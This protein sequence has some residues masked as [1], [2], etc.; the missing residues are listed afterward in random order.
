[1]S[2]SFDVKKQPV[3]TP[4][5]LYDV[6][7]VGA[8]PYGLSTTAHIL[9]RGLRVR[10]FG[11]PLA[12]WREHMPEH[13]LL[14][15]YWWATNLSD[16]QHRYGLERYLQA[17]GQQAI[18][19]LPIETFIDYG[20]WFQKQAVPNVDETYVESIERVE[21][22][23][24]LTL[25]DGRVVHSRAVVMAPGLRYYT[26]CP[27]EYSH[28]PSEF[29]S[30]TADHHTFER[31]IGKKLVVIGGGQGALETAAL[32]RESG[33]DVQIVTRSPLIWIEGSGSFPEHRPLLERLRN[34]K[35][36]ISTGW[37]SWRLEHFPYAF[38]RLSR[39]V[40]DQTLMG[41]GSYGPMGASWLKPRIIGEMPV[42]ELQRVQET[43]V[44][45]A[46]VELH[47]SNETRLT[48]DHIML[49]TGYRVD[50]HKLPMLHPSIVSQIQTYQNAPVLNNYFESSVPGMY[51]LGISSLSSCGPLYR[52]VVGADAAA[53]RVAHAVAIRV[54]H[55]R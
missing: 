5:T 51:F 31:F 25:K 10:I 44:T 3:S 46:G 15:S 34:P 37:F 55:A 9:K 53:R 4:A 13:M 47:L 29:V 35:A 48:V 17:T 54:A 52:F 23:F 43:R 24:E 8:G 30:H 28:L 41:R 36:G 49:G 16:P 18:D 21:R 27:T 33:V 38:Q 2:T 11:K 42:Y 14:R 19:P 12:F 6:V 1:M 40:K 50:I 39:E 45:D 20:L 32:A 22:Q 26:Y 7:V